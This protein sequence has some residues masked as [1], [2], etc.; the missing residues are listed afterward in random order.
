MNTIAIKDITTGTRLIS[1]VTHLL[2]I[3]DGPATQHGDGWR[4]PVRDRVPCDF[5]A[6]DNATDTLLLATA[7]TPTPEMRE[8]QSPE[9]AEGE[10]RNAERSKT[11]LGLWLSTNA[12]D[13]ASH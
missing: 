7:E 9:G 6:A 12:D 11:C 2:A 4:V 5:I 13:A 1:P 8:A 3:A 10:V